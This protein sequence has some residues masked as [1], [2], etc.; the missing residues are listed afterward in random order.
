MRFLREGQKIFLS[1]AESPTNPMEI[2]NMINRQRIKDNK[3]FITDLS[4]NHNFRIQTQI[5]LIAAALYLF[6]PVVIFDSAHWGQTDSIAA[7]LVL[8]S[9]IALLKGRVYLTTIIAIIAFETKVQT[10]V[11]TPLIFILIFRFYGLKKTI[12]AFSVAALTFLV[13]NLP[14]ILSGTMVRAMSLIIDSAKNFPLASL[15][16]YNFWWVITN[17]NGF[18]TADTILISNTISFKSFGMLLYVLAYS[19]ISLFLFLKSKSQDLKN[20]PINSLEIQNYQS[21]FLSFSAAAF[22]FYMLPTQIHERYIFPFFLFF[23]V[24]TSLTIYIYLVEKNLKNKVAVLRSKKLKNIAILSICYLCITT[25]LTFLTL[26]FVLVENYPENGFPIITLLNKSS[27]YISITI[28]IAWINIILYL[29][30]IYSIIKRLP[31]KI[32]YFVFLAFI[33]LII[34]QLALNFI[35]R[36]QTVV[37]LSSIKPASSEQDWGELKINKTVDDRLL[38]S[39]YV[40]YKEGLGTHANSKITYDLAGDYN[41]FTTDIGVDTESQDSATVEFIIEGDGKRLY[42]SPVMKKWLWPQHVEV[43]VTGVKTLTLIVT[44]AQDDKNGDHADWLNPKLYK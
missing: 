1:D 38:S 11:F 32:V 37:S 2:T 26:H 20:S 42:K 19:F 17:G 41:I 34:G 27:S 9:L 4:K 5:P 28:F 15:N 35:K 22:S 13:I 39:S 21:I 36:Q 25:L 10:V 3:N 31:G 40:W 16:A 44:D 23:T 43:P 14:Y 12:E 7:T 30:L 8:L 33:T 18:H 29:S 6:N 24:F